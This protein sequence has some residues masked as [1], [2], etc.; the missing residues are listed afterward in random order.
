MLYCVVLCNPEAINV[1]ACKEY[2]NLWLHCLQLKICIMCSSH[3][4]C[5]GDIDKFG[6][7]KSKFQVM[8][9]NNV[10]SATKTM[11]NILSRKIYVNPKRIEFLRKLEADLPPIPAE[12]D[13]VIKGRGDEGNKGEA[14]SHDCAPMLLINFTDEQVRCLPSSRHNRKLTV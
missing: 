12:C 11:Q 5:A 8:A 10:R 14:Q 7:Q 4:S 1:D 6:Q 2:L 13:K 9:R 3:A